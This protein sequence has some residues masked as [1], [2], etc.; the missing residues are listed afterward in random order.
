MKEG[1]VVYYTQVQTLA[2]E[3]L[4]YAVVNTVLTPYYD[5]YDDWGTKPPNWSAHC[6]NP[7]HTRPPTQTI[8]SFQTTA[9]TLPSTLTLQAEPNIEELR[10]FIINTLHPLLAVDH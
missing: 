10:P 3:V 1:G 2:V 8:G 6:Y 9:N 7:R 5:S 4:Y